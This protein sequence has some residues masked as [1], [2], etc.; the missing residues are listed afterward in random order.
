M[1]GRE[2][3]PEEPSKELDGGLLIIDE[4]SM[5]DTVLFQQLLTAIPS[6]MQV[7]LVG[8]KDQLPSVGASL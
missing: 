1:T 6:H 3:G 8:D 5:V 7:I 2:D 4:M